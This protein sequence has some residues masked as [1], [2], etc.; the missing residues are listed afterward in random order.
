MHVD[1]IMKMKKEAQRLRP[2]DDCLYAARLMAERNTGFLPVCDRAGVVVGVLT[3]RDLVLRVMAKNVPPGSV[4]VEQVMSRDVISC[5]PDDDLRRCEGLMATYRKARLPVCDES[6]RLV[7]VL[8]L[9]DVAQAD[10]SVEAGAVLREVTARE[11]PVRL[12]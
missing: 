5:R 12:Q 2:E 7:G 9:S 1:A 10:R 8:S 11:S 3:D 4:P 6:G